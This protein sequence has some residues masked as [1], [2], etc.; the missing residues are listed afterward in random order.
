METIDNRLLYLLFCGIGVYTESRHTNQEYLNLVVSGMNSGYIKIIFCDGGLAYGLNLPVGTI[1]LNDEK[2]VSKIDPGVTYP[3]IIEQ[4][5]IKTIFQMLGRAGRGGNLSYRADAY[6]IGSG[7]LGPMLDHYLT[8]SLE[9]GS[10]DEAVNIMARYH[11]R[12]QG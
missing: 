1:V 4:H 11:R 3:S 6:M 12:L 10:R 7:R 5:S 9:E 2:I 8:D